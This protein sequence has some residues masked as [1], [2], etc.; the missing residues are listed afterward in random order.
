MKAEI[1]ADGC[2]ILEE[3]K[4]S[5]LITASAKTLFLY[6]RSRTRSKEEA[7]D[8][9]QDILYALLKAKGSFCNA[10]AFYGFMWAVAGNVYKNWCK[11][12]AGAS[13]AVL[14][15]HIA[16][17]GVSFVEQLEREADFMLLYRE[18]SLLS[19]QHRKVI[20]HYYF[21]ARKVSEISQ[22]TGISESMVKF[23][24]F[25]SRQ[26]L[27]EGMTMERFNRGLSFNP[28][29][30][31]IM[32]YG[33]EHFKPEEASV[34][35]DFRSLIAQNILL[36]CHNDRC[37]TEE[38][39]LQLGVAVPYLEKDLQTLCDNHL[40]V[41]RSGRYETA[42]V[43][44]TKD[45]ATEAR[46]KTRHLQREIA[47]IVGTCLQED[48]ESIKDI[49][50]QTGF[51]ND[52]LLKWHIAVAML[53]EA[54]LKKYHDSLQLV[55]P[56][57][58]LGV[59]AFVWGVEPDPAQPGGIA[60]LTPRNKYGDLLFY[61]DFYQLDGMNTG[62]GYFACHPNRVNIA[63]DIA[64]S[65]T[66]HF[67]ENDLA[68][69]AE[70]IKRGFVQ[71]VGNGLDLCFP[72]YTRQQYASLLALINDKTTAIAEKTREMVKQ[73]TD[74]LMQHTPVPMKK[75]AENIGWFKMTDAIL[76]PV[77]MILDSGVLPAISENTCP[78]AYV[79]LH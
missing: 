1:I 20:I 24:L 32:I 29:K 60:T 17:R 3:V 5:E 23:L 46:E 27:K 47:E 35:G 77:K 31:D 53:H 49:G 28:G 44:F 50:F 75:E 48:L 37:T 11:K 55:Y 52:N 4:P 79:V 34:C 41:K 58:Y 57:K 33:G 70:L 10:K 61:L 22:M 72:V 42:I 63:L 18:L 76:L 39:S 7:E 14:G 62:G 2:E 71:R 13:A 8:L 59:E 6:C 68:E 38:I 65:E 15:E 16:D 64:R 25:K 19:E 56:I 45:F 30:L 73:T 74:I 66:G 9:S 26:K 36:A 43:L 51:D 40:L 69:V 21:E 12:R 54:V 78:T 67:S